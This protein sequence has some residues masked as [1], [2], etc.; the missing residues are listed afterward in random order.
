MPRKNRAYKK[1]EPHR[2]ARLFVI[3]AEG[4]R[5]DGYFRFFNERNQRIQIKIA[6]R[7]ENKSAPNFFLERVEKMIAD[8]IWSPKDDDLLW[9]VLDVDKW[10]REEI[11]NLKTACDSEENWD[12]A[13]S[14]PCFEVWLIFH[15]QSEI[16]NKELSCQELKTFLHQASGGGF[17]IN[18]FAFNLQTAVENGKA[19]DTNPTGYYPDV[20]QT[21]VYLLGEQLLQL[22]GNNWKN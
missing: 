19:A 11:E 12:I 1:G 10:K 22:L 3:V 15:V 13:I 18:R 7:E 14:N 9:F 20:M 17:E 6:A 8:G 16:S 5:E 21:K 2:D 4:E